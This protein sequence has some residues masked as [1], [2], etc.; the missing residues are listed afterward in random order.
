MFVLNVSVWGSRHSIKA[1]RALSVFVLLSCFAA[2]MPTITSHVHGMRAQS[3]APAGNQPTSD[4]HLLIHCDGL[5]SFQST[6][7]FICVYFLFTIEL[8][9]L[10]GLMLPRSLVVHVIALTVASA[11]ALPSVIHTEP[12]GCFFLPVLAACARHQMGTQSLRMFGTQHFH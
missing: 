12:P 11:F 2:R 3:K 4:R 10:L 9:V 8:K 7:A 5:M 6:A 1:G